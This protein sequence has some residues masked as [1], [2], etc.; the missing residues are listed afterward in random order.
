[1]CS[2]LVGDWGVRVVGGWLMRVRC[3]GV[4]VYLIHVSL[5]VCAWGSIWVYV[6]VCICV[7]VRMCECACTVLHL[8]RTIV[9]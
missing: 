8:V 4:R 2:V 3:I 6:Y 1:M 7:P 5:C 9:S